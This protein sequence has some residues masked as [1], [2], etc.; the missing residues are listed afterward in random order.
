[1]TVKII[2][3]A[4][5]L[6][7][8]CGGAQPAK[9]EAKVPET[10]TEVKHGAEIALFKPDSKAG[11]TVNEALENRRSW[12]EYAP[13]ALSLEELSG[14]MWAAGGVN[15]PA[16]GRLTAPSALALYPVRVYAFFAEGVYSYDA[17]AR[18]LVRVAE[19]DPAAGWPSAQDF[20]YAAPLNL[21]YIADMSAYE[22]K[23]IPAEHVRYLC[24]RD[25]ARI[26]RECEPLYGGSRAEVRSRAAAPPKPNC[27][28]PSVLIPDAISWRWRR[29]SANRPGGE[30]RIGGAALNRSFFISVRPEQPDFYPG[31]GSDPLLTEYPAAGSD[32]DYFS[33]RAGTCQDVSGPAGSFLPDGVSG[34]GFPGFFVTLCLRNQNRLTFMTKLRIP[35]PRSRPVACAGLLHGCLRCTPENST[36]LPTAV[37]SPRAASLSGPAGLTR[38]AAPPCRCSSCCRDFSCFRCGSARATFFAPAFRARG[39]AVSGV[40]RALRKSTS[41]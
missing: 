10:V 36:I 13:E 38:C 26:C 15:R 27:S 32:R 8:A 12:R 11:M 25:A 2:T 33:D 40:V 24:G 7:A 1:M 4:A 34:C 29:P 21:V 6:L 41:S 5:L 19:G 14:V 39:G 37:W 31:E 3:C 16:D 28:R 23:N 35:K 17:K 20:V 18:K 22:G 9:E 30:T